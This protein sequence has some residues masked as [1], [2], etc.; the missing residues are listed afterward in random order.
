MLR[1]P[2]TG[3]VLASAHD[4]GREHKIVSA[5]QGNT[6]PVAEICGL[7]KDVSVNE[8]PFYVMRFVDG[9]VFNSIEDSQQFSMPDRASIADHVVEMNFE[10]FDADPFGYKS[11]PPLEYN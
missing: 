5:L 9:I 8:A 10:N 6:V 4:M 11:A 1:R 2:P 3:H 7:C